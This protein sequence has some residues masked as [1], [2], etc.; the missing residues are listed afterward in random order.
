LNN[1]AAVPSWSD[2]AASFI[3]AHVRGY[4]GISRLQRDASTREYFRVSAEDAS[5]I[6][7][8]DA[9]FIHVGESDYP[10][11]IMYG[12]LKDFVPV[13]Y[14]HAFDCEKGLLLLQD[15][16]DDCLEYAYPFFD[17]ERTMRVYESCIDYLFAIQRLK[18]EGA[19][20]FRRGFDVAMLM[21]EF[22]F[23]IKHC[24]TG[25]FRA[26]AAPGELEM[27]RAEFLKI[28]GILHRP[29]IF[30]LN[31]RDFHSRNI[32]IFEGTPYLIDFQDARMGLPQYDAVSLLRDSYLRLETEMYA[33]L[34]SYYYE[35]GMDTGVFS[36]GRD[37][38]EYYFDIM[39]FQR[40]IKALGTFGYQSATGNRRYEKYIPGTVA[41]LPEYAEGRD[42]LKKAWL[43]LNRHIG[44]KV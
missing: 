20:P 11:L 23:F 28:S 33:Y 39:A 7:C 30:V 21:H 41:Y 3:S 42:E 35:G 16:G 4:E 10:F 1:G 18:G 15:M 22:D 25:F 12:L 44:Q 27:L 19:V 34:K 13:P 9:A 43:I 29:E 36:M 5:Y 37:E 38:F 26:V 17:R 31:H 32:I 6:L 2:D 8:R 14:V 40:N 24:L